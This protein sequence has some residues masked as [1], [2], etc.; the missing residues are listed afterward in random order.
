LTDPEVNVLISLADQIAGWS[1]FKARS[2]G[3]RHR[4]VTLSCN[5][6]LPSF[7][8]RLLRSK[9][10]KDIYRKEYGRLSHISRE[11]RL[12]IVTAMYIAHIGE[13]AAASLLSEVFSVDVGTL[14]ARLE[15]GGGGGLRLLRVRGEFVQTVPSIGA[16]NLLKEIIDDEL[17][18]EAVNRVLVSLTQSARRDRYREY[19]F[20]QMMRYNILHPVMDER[21]SII[22]FFDKLSKLDSIRRRV[23]FWLQWSIALRELHAFLDAERKLEQGYR[24]AEVYERTRGSKWDRRQLDDVKAKLMVARCLHAPGLAS[25][26]LFR[27]M[28]AAC[29]IVN[30]LLS[31]ESLTHHPYETIEMICELYHEKRNILDAPLATLALSLIEKMLNLAQKRLGQLPVGY[32]T[33]KA[34]DTLKSARNIVVQ[35]ASG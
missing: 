2:P 18:I 21:S 7:L 6:S 12:A 24:E 19:V 27:D 34:F 33:G 16:T 10:V 23:L 31:A 17:I 28:R 32:Q 22:S 26:Q 11:E 30:R 20:N 3:D 25:E 35:A 29:D 14:V 4:F 8:L 5:S 9:H 1:E 15:N 13:R